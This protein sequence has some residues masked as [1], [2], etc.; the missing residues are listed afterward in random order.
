M[1]LTGTNTVHVRFRDA[2]G[3]IS[4]VHWDAGVT[5]R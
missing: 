1:E 2:A 3:N 4:P 5:G